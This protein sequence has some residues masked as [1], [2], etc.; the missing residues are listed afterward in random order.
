MPHQGITDILG[1]QGYVHIHQPHHNTNTAHRIIYKTKKINAQCIQNKTAICS[2][3]SVVHPPL[4]RRNQWSNPTLTDTKRTMLANF[5][6]VSKIFTSVRENSV[7]ITDVFHT[8]S[9]QPKPTSLSPPAPIIHTLT[10]VGIIYCTYLY[11]Y[12][13]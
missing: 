1:C 12:V 7:S 2:T 8:L 3:A 13:I 4:A 11:V 6:F 5:Y 10:R 9:K